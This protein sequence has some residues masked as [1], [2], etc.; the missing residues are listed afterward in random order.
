MGSLRWLVDSPHKWSVIGNSDNFCVPCPNTVDKILAIPVIWYAMAAVWRHSNAVH[1][2]CF[3]FSLYPPHHRLIGI[4]ELSKKFVAQWSDPIG[5]HQGIQLSYILIFHSGDFFSII[6]IKSLFVL[7]SQN[8]WY[9]IS[10]IIKSFRWFTT[11]MILTLL[12]ATTNISN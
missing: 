3:S 10:L 8:Y 6:R 9:P 11:N 1:V 2:F 4:Y 12:R 5:R 7:K